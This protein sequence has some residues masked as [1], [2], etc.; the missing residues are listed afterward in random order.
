MP[1]SVLPATES[2]FTECD[3]L[4]CPDYSA[5][6]QHCLLQDFSIESRWIESEVRTK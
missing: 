1:M 5:I 2:V 4:V 3:Y 6:Y